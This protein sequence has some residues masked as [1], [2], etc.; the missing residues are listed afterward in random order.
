MLDGVSAYADFIAR[1]TQSLGGD[2][3]DPLFVPS[4]LFDFQIYLLEWAQRIGRCAILADCGLGKTVIQ[5][6]WAQNI[7]EHDNARVLVLT[8]L[9][10][11]PQTVRE[12]EKFGI[13][14]TRSRDATNLPRSGIVVT[15]YERLENFD[16]SDFAAVVCDESSILKSFA[17]VRRQQ[18]TDFMRKVRYRLLCT[19]TAAPND[20]DELGTSSEALGHLGYVD[21]LGR[22]FVANDGRGAAAKRGWGKELK[23]RLKGHA[24]DPFWRWVS[25]WACA[26]RKPS[27]LG[28]DDGGFVLPPLTEQEHLLSV[29][30][31]RPPPGQLFEIEAVGFHEQGEAVRRTL[32]ERCEAVSR[33]VNGTGKPALVWCNLNVEGDLLEEMIPGSV[34]VSG[35]DADA[36]KEERLMAFADGKIRVLVT[37][38]RIGAWG[39]NFQRCSHV[40]VMP[41]HSF[42]AYYQGIRRCWRYGQEY[43]VQVDIVGTW[44]LSQVMKNLRRKATQADEM[45]DRLVSIGREA[46][47]GQRH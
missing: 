42:E 47:L 8:P 34:Q 43:P 15:N 13:E 28:F 18:I 35:S 10:V 24:E 16:P 3:F 30:D 21:M 14:C 19:A 37:K 5:L 26:V 41:T 12:G 11:S 6:S 36:V 45:F 7:V 20:Y 25:G 23:F 2:G 17:G 32:R 4:G 1:R 31:V 9:A 38:P 40:V 46:R 22:F 39:L 33:L 44:G 29:A 27:D